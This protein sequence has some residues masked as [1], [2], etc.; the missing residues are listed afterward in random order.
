MKEAVDAEKAE[1][2][3]TCQAIIKYVIGY[4]V[5]DEDRK[6]TWLEDADNFTSQVITHISTPSSSNRIYILICS[7]MIV[8]TAYESSRA[9]FTHALVTFP[10]KK[11]IWLRAAAFERQHGTRESLET[12]L[13]KAVSHCPQAEVLWLMGAK[14]KWLAGMNSSFSTN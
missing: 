13:Q 14:S 6:H 1:G 2:V 5:E 3:L 10:S 7:F 11:S 9:V 8:K 12:L 4:G